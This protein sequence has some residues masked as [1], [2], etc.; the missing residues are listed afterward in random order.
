M[1]ARALLANP[2]LYAG[3]DAC[4]WSAVETFLSNVARCPLPFK[5]VQHHLSE[6]CGPGMGPNKSAL[7][8]KQERARVMG[9]G[10]MLD[11]VDFLDGVREVR[12][13]PVGG[14]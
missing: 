5:L 13:V 3:Y 8:T 14:K 1:S 6:M 7:L 4:P 12:R 9:C 2:A 11:L 10:N